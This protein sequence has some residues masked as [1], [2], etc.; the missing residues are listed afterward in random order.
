VPDTIE[1]ADSATTVAAPVTGPTSG[2]TMRE[3]VAEVTQIRASDPD[4]IARAALAR[5]ARPTVRGD[6]RL[7]IIA[8]D[9]PAR[10]AFGV[11]DRPMAM[12]SRVDLLER[13]VIALARPGVDG[14]LASPDVLED[15][16]L[17]GALEDKVVF[18]SMNRGGLQGAEFELDD[19]FTGYDALGCAEMR[20][21][22][23]KTLTRIALG[24]P[25]TVATME[26]TAK[27][28]NELAA[29]KLIAL[30]EPFWS[31]RAGGRVDND[32]S[33]D[34]VIKSIGIC[35]ALGRTSAY[36]WLKLPVVPDMER[37]MDS[38]TLPTLLLG[39]DPATDAEATYQSWRDALSLPAVR[40][41]VVG[42]TLLYP[43]DDDVTAA[44]DT[45]VS[46]VR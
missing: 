4:A 38:T 44:V 1:K 27:A 41:L 37:V 6:G 14:L 8:A 40:G 22:G 33:P 19:R 20:L 35:S 2:R 9:H 18:G 36:T 11:G 26:A 34:A 10:G 25:G 30:V 21:N 23:G 32:L 39:G 3:R 28:V 7:M 29:R 45:A 13:L 24:D 16:L 42:R 12:A 15:L 17:L 31:S 5:A 43:G 46:M